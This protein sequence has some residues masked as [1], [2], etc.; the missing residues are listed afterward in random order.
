MFPNNKLPQK[1]VN[2]TEALAHK[3]RREIFELLLDNPSLSFNQIMKIMNIGRAS[4]AY[5]LKILA[6]AG[7]I[8][9]F[10]D[11]R[12]G[13][14]DHSYYEISAFGKNISQ[15]LFEKVEHSM[16]LELFNTINFRNVEKF[17]IT[18]KSRKKVSGQDEKEGE[19]PSEI[20]II[21]G[22]EA[23]KTFEWKAQVL[24]FKDYKKL[25]TTKFKM[26]NEG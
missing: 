9:N 5:H 11:K 26:D 15:E 2:M 10:Y 1:F 18:S 20:V 13:V 4:L 25:Y 23:I 22:D 16:K 3:T 17:N 7:L 14:K 6:N 19:Q 8:N 24:D 12:Q 21:Q